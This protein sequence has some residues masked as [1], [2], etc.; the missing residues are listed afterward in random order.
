MATAVISYVFD[1]LTLTN[2]FCFEYAGVKDFRIDR[3]CRDYDWPEFIELDEYVR[4]SVNTSGNI[5]EA[6]EGGSDESKIETLKSTSEIK[7]KQITPLRMIL[8][9]IEELDE[10]EQAEVVASHHIIM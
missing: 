9:R 3:C 7:R 1:A 6:T 2:A 5:E 8:S 4:L 10:S